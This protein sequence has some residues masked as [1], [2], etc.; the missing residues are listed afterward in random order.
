MLKRKVLSRK[1][2]GCRPRSGKLHESAQRKKLTWATS[3]PRHFSDQ[4]GR[5]IGDDSR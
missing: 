1:V 3:R 5:T 2:K 4:P